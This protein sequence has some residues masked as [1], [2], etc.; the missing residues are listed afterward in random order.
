MSRIGD[1]RSNTTKTGSKINSI[2]CI[3]CTSNENAESHIAYNDL[4]SDEDEPV[5]TVLYQLYKST[6][7]NYNIAECNNEIN[8]NEYDSSDTD[9]ENQMNT[10]IKKKKMMMVNLYGVVHNI[11]I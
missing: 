4:S 10:P 9:I 2:V 7:A 5:S 3:T 8:G 6:N 11:V 1:R